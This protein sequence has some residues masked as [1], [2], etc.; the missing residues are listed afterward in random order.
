MSVGTFSSTVEYYSLDTTY[1]ANEISRL[2]LGLPRLK[3]LTYTDL[4]LE[5]WWREIYTVRGGVRPY[6]QGKFTISSFIT[7]VRI[8]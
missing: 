1:S 6:D 2:V 8:Y 3:S 4:A 5:A 7:F